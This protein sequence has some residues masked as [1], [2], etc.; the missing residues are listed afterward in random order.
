MASASLELNMSVGKCI[1]GHR[2]HWLDPALQCPYR[3]GNILKERRDILR[4]LAKGVNS[5]AE[6]TRTTTAVSIALPHLC[7]GMVMTVPPLCAGG[8]VSKQTR[9]VAEVSAASGRSVQVS[10]P[11]HLVSVLYWQ[12]PGQHTWQGP[13]DCY[14][15][16]G[17]KLSRCLCRF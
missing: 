4:Q 17:V 15:K 5:A 16:R 10:K 8:M 13:F 11:T 7:C 3:H 9:L 14:G 12:F 6:E 2:V 1:A